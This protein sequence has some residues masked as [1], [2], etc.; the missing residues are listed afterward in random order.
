[1]AVSAGT[2]YI[3][4]DAKFTEFRKG[5]DSSVTA[6][7]DSA[8]SKMRSTFGR[9]AAGIGGLFAFDR[10]FTF[11][12]SAVT[13]AREAAA[14]A[15]QTEQVIKTTGGAAQVTGAQVAAYANKLSVAAGVDNDLVQ[16][17]QNLLLT[18]TNIRNAA[19][20]NNNIFDQATTLALDLSVA[21]KQDLKA[22]A[23]QLGKALNDPVKGV[24]ALQRV[25]VSFT[26]QQRAQIQ[27]LVDAG[28]AM[29]AQKVILAELRKQ[30]GGSA[31]AQ[32]DASSRA[33]A[34]WNNMK[35][36]LGTALMPVIEKVST[37]LA[38]KLPAA[39]EVIRQKFRDWQPT[40]EAVGSVL[41][42][43][44]RFIGDNIKVIATLAAAVATATVA[45]KAYQLASKAVA[46]VSKA[47]AATQTAL[48]AVMSANPIVLVI[49]GLA[50][51]AIALVI[52]YKRSETFRAVVQAVWGA[53]RTAVVA[54]V[55]VIRTAVITIQTVITTIRSI[56]TGTMNTIST[57][58]STGLA[59]VRNAFAS[60]W[61]GIR[62]LTASAMD[63]IVGFFRALP[64]RILGLV[65]SIGSAALSVGKAIIAGIA[66]G[67]SGAI[68]VMGDIAG[69]IGRAVRDFINTQIIDRINR[70]LE[71]RI[72]GPGFLPDIN[73]DPP[74]IPRLHSGGIVPG[75]P[76]QDVLALLRA[77][78]LVVAS[79]GTVNGRRVGGVNVTQIF[80]ERVDPDL[81]VAA[82]RRAEQLY[83][84]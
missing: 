26:A 78:E 1:M 6:A 52:A 8:S 10:A 48:N 67:V 12:S 17:G 36:A 56:V 41:A 2:A 16:A 21:F 45:W 55:N 68:G 33:A 82:Q 25:G 31:V 14:I 74:D 66:R 57:V 84:G 18:F 75:R 7:A 22:S 34:A 81:L 40:L 77:G 63:G 49:A 43:I 42:T 32:A 79:D 60:A 44:A 51:L 19:G 58:V 62:A 15:R 80:N 47:V 9:A 30:I 70:A 72:K 29:G 71:I 53:L 5:L 73:L 23:I 4:L 20:K 24:T 11:V 50:A 54:A 64:G 61:G 69:A 28:D 35:D 83:A 76:G 38:D 3:D 37:W 27:A 46:A 65:S 59:V 13:G 39:V